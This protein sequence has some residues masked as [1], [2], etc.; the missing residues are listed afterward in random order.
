MYI[1]YISLMTLYYNYNNTNIVIANDEHLIKN[2]VENV[3][4]RCAIVDD[5]SLQRLSIVKLVKDHPNLTL[6]GEYGNAI[7]TKNGLLDTEVDLIFLDVEMPIL[8]GFDLLDDLKTKPQIIF[9][10]GK[11]QYAYKA[12]DYEAIDYIQK[13]V[14][15]DRFTKAVSKAIK[16]QRLENEVSSTD[17]D[18]FIFVKSNLK[19]RK[20]VLGNL[21]YIEALGDYVKFVTNTDS[22]VVLATMKSFEQELPDNSFLRIHKSYI[23]NLDRIERYNSRE[24]EIDGEKIPLS[25][26][27]KTILAEAL[28]AN[29]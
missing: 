27:K 12:F 11:T 16:Q 2:P 28:T 13:P 15:R 9:V 1:E 25:R 6:V 10:T 20:V 14:T 5:S 17:D 21:K 19:R 24:V 8:S 18:R 3:L 22:F 23:V 7:E 26:H 29:Q 4:L